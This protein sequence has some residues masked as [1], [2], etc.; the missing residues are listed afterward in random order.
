MYENFNIINER[1]KLSTCLYLNEGILMC[2]GLMTQCLECSLSSLGKSQYKSLNMD[3]FFCLSCFA[4][5][6]FFTAPDDQ[7]TFDQ[8]AVLNN[9][10][11]VRF[12][13][14]QLFLILQKSS[15][16]VL[17]QVR[18]SHHGNSRNEIG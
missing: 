18:G 16:T 2:V 14:R 13:V 11:T 7:M 1:R 3:F 5:E 10:M 4:L 15:S 9:L 17:C 12:K 8:S 6:C